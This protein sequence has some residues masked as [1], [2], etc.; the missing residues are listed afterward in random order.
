MYAGKAGIRAFLLRLYATDP[1]HQLTGL[2]G[3][4]ASLI[5]A[6]APPLSGNRA[7]L[8][9]ITE[10]PRP[11]RPWR[12]DMVMLAYTSNL[13]ELDVYVLLTAD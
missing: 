8:P 7:L 4:G 9:S 10:R 1:G 3:L 11:R 6:P 13:F 5:G 2:S 12:R